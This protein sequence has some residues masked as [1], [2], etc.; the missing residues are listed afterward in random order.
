MH[1]TSDRQG[2]DMELSLLM[3]TGSRVKEKKDPMI[4]EDFFY[5]S[6]SSFPSTV[7]RT[8]PWP[9]KGKARHPIRGIARHC[10]TLH[11]LGLESIEPRTN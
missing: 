10:N 4:L 2:H 9:I 5:F 8:L 3:S 7:T 1:G 6:F 11:Q